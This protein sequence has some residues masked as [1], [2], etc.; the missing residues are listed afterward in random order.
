MNGYDLIRSLEYSG[1]YP[2]ES[3]PLSLAWGIVIAAAI[4]G[5]SLILKAWIDVRRVRPNR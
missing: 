3:E 1:S 2:V 5:F 4:L